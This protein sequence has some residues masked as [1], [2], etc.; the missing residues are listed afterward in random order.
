MTDGSAPSWS[1]VVVLFSTSI[2]SGWLG[3]REVLSLQHC[4]FSQLVRLA[5]SYEGN[6][7]FSQ[8]LILKFSLNFLQLRLSALLILMGKF[9]FR[10]KKT[11]Y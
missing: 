2:F 5:T 9:M 11:G 7:L 4:R 10:G 6:R 1:V 3:F 8:L